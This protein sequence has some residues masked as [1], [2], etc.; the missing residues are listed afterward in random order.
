MI[1]EKWKILEIGGINRFL[2]DQML[3]MIVLLT[4]MNVQYTAL[5]EVIFVKFLTI[6]IL[7]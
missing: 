6:Y 1:S 5:I 2:V 3:R 7:Y 4:I